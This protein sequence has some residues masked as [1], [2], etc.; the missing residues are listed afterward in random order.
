M[1]SE[2]LDPK[3]VGIAMDLIVLSMLNEKVRKVC[4][5]K[6]FGTK[7]GEQLNKSEQLC[8]AKC[9]DRFYEAHS[10]VSQ[11]SSEATQNFS[12]LK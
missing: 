4:F 8:L 2:S 1:S 10:I 5:K 11:A 12:I 7:F 3:N 6:C 9:M